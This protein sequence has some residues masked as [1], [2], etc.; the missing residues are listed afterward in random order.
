MVN[1]V[2]G[3]QTIWASSLPE[4]TTAQRAE[5][6][7]LTQALWVAQGKNINIYTDSRYAF[8]TTH[9][10]GAIYRQR[11]YSHLLGKILKI[12]KKS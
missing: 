3:K 10:H 9:I 5:L 2:N 8:T 7:A 1:G 6:I 12:K 11:G 4:G